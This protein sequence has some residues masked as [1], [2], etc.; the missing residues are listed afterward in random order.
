MKQESA[1][2]IVEDIDAVFGYT[3]SEVIAP[4][5][6]AI[7]IASVQTENSPKKAEGDVFI[8]VYGTNGDNV[9]RL[10]VAMDA[11]DN[12]RKIIMKAASQYA[13]KKFFDK[14]EPCDCPACTKA[15]NAHKN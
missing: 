13:V 9:H 1:K 12:L 7:F 4:H 2:K 5:D 8:G 3:G 15:R 11:D 14:D 10:L 6:T